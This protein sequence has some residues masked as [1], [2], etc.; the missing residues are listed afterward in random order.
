LNNTSFTLNGNNNIEHG[1]NDTVALL[2]SN[3]PFYGSYN[4]VSINGSNDPFYGTGNVA[5]GA[6][7]YGMYGTG[8]FIGYL[9]YGSS[10]LIAGAP[11]TMN[12]VAQYD[13]SV[14]DT[15]G[16]T[17]A[18]ASRSL[19]NEAIAAAANPT[20]TTAPSPFNGAIWSGSTITWSFGAGTSTTDAPISG[21]IQM[22]YQASIEKALQTWADAS[23]MVFKEVPASPASDIVIG[24]GNFDTRLRTHSLQVEQDGCGD[25]NG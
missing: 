12:V 11:T 3:D 15:A 9:P 6:A 2:G 23:G 18:E 22:R 19:A 7:G 16:A 14:G 24:W 8:Y 4:S 10:G 20:V 13:L 21:T 17:S 5:S 1:N 25:A